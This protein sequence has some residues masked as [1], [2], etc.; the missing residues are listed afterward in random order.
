MPSRQKLVE[1]LRKLLALC[2]SPNVHESEQARKASDR[3][4]LKHGITEDDVRQLD[5]SAYYELSLGLAGWNAAWRFTLV[6]LA[7][8]VH[9]VKA[10][11][12]RK[13]ARQLVKLCGSKV[14]VELAHKLFQKL[15]TVVK[16]IESRVVRDGRIVRFAEMVGDLSVREISDAFRRG[17]VAG[18]VNCY[19]RARR[20]KK[21]AEDLATSRPVPRETDGKVP[22][23]GSSTSGK[24][25]MRLDV[26]VKATFASKYDEKVREKYAPET[27]PIDLAGDSHPMLFDLGFE[28]ALAH[29]LVGDD[30]D[31]SLRRWTPG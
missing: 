12:L 1:K 14:E 22:E 23:S 20:K 13:G 29:V 18:I 30:Y 17:V 15:L 28:Y 4:M 31:V 16:E 7:A 24:E 21:V 11:A 8:Q 2:S 6:T 25:L 10:V 27:R 9:G 26:L 5:D 3:L 19:W